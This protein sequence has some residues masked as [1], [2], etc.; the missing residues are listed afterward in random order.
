M[1][2]WFPR[3]TLTLEDSNDVSVGISRSMI[4][5]PCCGSLM[6]FASRERVWGGTD[7]LFLSAERE[8][9]GYKVRDLGLYWES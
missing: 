2:G 5:W 8:W 3:A 9:L 1:P 6:I 7:Q 4:Y